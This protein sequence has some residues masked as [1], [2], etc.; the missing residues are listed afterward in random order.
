M[1]EATISFDEFKR[2]DI[3]VAR[4]IEAREHPNADKLTVMKVDT[5]D[6]SKQIVAAI[7]KHYDSQAL[8]GRS[9]VL[10]NNLEPAKLRGETSEGMLLA[11]VDG[12]RVILVEPEKDVPAGT[13]VS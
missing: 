1:P 3:R 4:I 9:I 5:G 10:V 8:V 6:G 7:R 11:A 2:L 12:E 13:P